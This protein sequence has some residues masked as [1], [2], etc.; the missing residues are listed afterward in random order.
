MSGVEWS[1]PAIRP[2]LENRHLIIEGHRGPLDF[3]F[4]TWILDLDFGPGFRTS[5]LPRHLLLHL[6]HDRI[7]LFGDAGAEVSQLVVELGGDWVAQVL[8]PLVVTVEE[9]EVSAMPG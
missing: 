5:C 1:G 3:G 8:I 7:R 6:S 9:L 2:G 4:G